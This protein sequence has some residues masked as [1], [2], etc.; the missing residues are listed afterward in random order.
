MQSEL[1]ANALVPL[2]LVPEIEAAA[3]EEHRA[4]SELVGEAVERY[5]AER[6]WLRR[7][8]AHAKIARGFASLGEGKGLNGEAAI[9]ELLAELDGPISRR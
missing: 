3:A 2:A 1:P 6:R 9:A 4:P 8:E 7:D 5:L